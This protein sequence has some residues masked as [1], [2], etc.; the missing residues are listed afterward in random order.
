[1]SVLNVAVIGAG[2]SGLCAAKY[3]LKEGFNVTVYEQ[4]EVLGGIWWYT[5]QT[6]KDKYGL[7][8]HTAMYQGLRTNLP[9]Q[10]MEFPDFHYPEGTKSYPPQAEVLKF[11]HSYADKFDLK[12][13]IKYSHVVIRCLPI[14]NGKWEVIVKDLP[15]NIFET[16]I[17]DV[18][19]VANGHFATPKIPHIDGASEFKG[20][21]IH[22]HDFRSA[23]VH[24][25][26]SVLVIGAGPSGMDLVAHLSKTATRVTF[27]QH[28]RPHET[29]EQF[30][31]RKQLLPSN[32]T[33]QENVKRF[34]ATGAEFLDGQHETFTTVYWATGKATS[35]T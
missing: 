33:L 28:K 15:S 23:E 16:K 35:Y 27:S 19:F 12:K 31:Q 1:M 7:N 17:Y 25:G 11:L 8:V 22:S 24:R 5:D 21:M 20:K 4:N 13:H 26:E 2:T 32:A 18:V 6:G 30:E 10:L 9:Y 14:E 29:K 34:T 3:A